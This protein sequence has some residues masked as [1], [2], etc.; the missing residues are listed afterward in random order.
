VI[1]LVRHGQT[2]PNRAGRLLGRADPPLNERGRHQA[3]ALA[4]VLEHGPAPRLVLTSPLLRARE[5]AERISAA[6]GTPVR[7][8]ERLI[9]LDYGE[10]D[11]RLLRDIPADVGTRWRSDPSFAAPGG[12]SL[13]DLRSRITPC[14]EG[15]MELASDGVIIVVSHVSPIKAIICWALDLDD[16]YAWR[17][18]LDVASI[19]RLVAGLNGPVLLSFNE[20]GHLLP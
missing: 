4:I 2:E 7:T 5:T 12:E 8:D 18:R 9:E 15:L 20:T 13:V 1:V 17:L 11:E 19:S 6:T 10:W 14:A 3:D 16:S